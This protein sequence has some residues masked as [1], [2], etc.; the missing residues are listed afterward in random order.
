M[1]D[2]N[3]IDFFCDNKLLNT[4]K[5]IFKYFWPQLDFFMQRQND[6]DGGAKSLLDLF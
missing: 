5:F 3:K 2:K 1:M 6:G 4:S